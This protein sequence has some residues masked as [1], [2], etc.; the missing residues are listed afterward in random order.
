MILQSNK[1]RK[2]HRKKCAF[3]YIY[4]LRLKEEKLL[5]F[6]QITNFTE[7]FLFVRRFSWCCWFFFFLLGKTIHSLNHREDTNSSLEFSVVYEKFIFITV[8]CSISFLW[9][10]RKSAIRVFENRA[11][12]IN[13]VSIDRFFI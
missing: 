13:N 1:N 2:A 6:Q 9:D 7:Q 4:L 10:L 11:P 3:L 5:I 8:E 12:T